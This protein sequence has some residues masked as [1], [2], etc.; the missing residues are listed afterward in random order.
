MLDGN[1]NV[2][3]L[4]KQLLLGMEELLRPS[5][6]FVAA[7][8]TEYSYLW[9][10]DQVWCALAYLFIGNYERTAHALQ[11]IFTILRTHQFKLENGWT[12]HVKY[13]PDSLSEV[14]EDWGHHQLDAWGLFLV[15][16][17]MLESRG[18]DIGKENIDILRELIQYLNR[19]EFWRSDVGMWEEKTEPHSSSIGLV[20]R[21]LEY[22]GEIV[23]VPTHM[24]AYG[25]KA[26]NDLLPG[27]NP[28][29]RPDMAQLTLIQLQCLQR[30]IADVV[31]RRIQ[32][33]LVVRNAD[34]IISGVIRYQRDEY[35]SSRDGPSPWPMGL[36]QLSSI[37]SLRGNREEA[38]IWF[39][40]GLTQAIAKGEA[41]HIPELIRDGEPKRTPLAWGNAQAVIALAHL[42]RGIL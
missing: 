12:I 19:R 25:Q 9:V 24:F 39:Q 33:Q 37:A 16:V 20:L 10:R 2:A 6:A 32:E 31:L 41:L 4:E 26:L 35:D 15:A 30:Q 13:N 1:I 14:T 7:P 28:D 3:G 22:M 38:R 23:E 36:F 42:A 8:T 17:G 34:G 40:R 27:E 18:S 11:P 5:G 29:G 21:G